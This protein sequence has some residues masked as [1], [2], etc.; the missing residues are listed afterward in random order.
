[1]IDLVEVLQVA[2]IG[3]LIGGL[4][5]I[6]KSYHKEGKIGDVAFFHLLTFILIFLVPC[7]LLFIGIFFGIITTSFFI[8][9]LIISVMIYVSNL[10]TPFFTTEAFK[11]TSQQIVS[12]IYAS[13]VILAGIINVLYW[14]MFWLG[15]I[16]GIIQLIVL[17]VAGFYNYNRSNISKIG[18]ILTLLAGLLINIMGWIVL[19]I[20]Y[21]LSKRNKS[22]RERIQQQNT[23][24]GM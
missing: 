2:I 19:I 14:G 3:G 11:N 17:S 22:A 9:L 13:L 8:T 5:S 15:A 18:L 6:I 7:F 23:S 16:L 1:M 4:C 21:Y 10:G 20:F 12:I 24:D